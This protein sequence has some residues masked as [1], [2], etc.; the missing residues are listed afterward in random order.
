MTDS[1]VVDPKK[2]QQIPNSED[3]MHQFM[4]DVRN[5]PRLTAEEEKQLAV[6]C[7]AGDSEAIKKMVASNL[8]LVVSIAREYA[9]K[10]VPLLDL[11]QEGSIGLIKAAEKFDHTKNFRFSTYATDWIRQ[12]IAR[13]V[14][15]YACI[16]RIPHYTAERMHK[17]LRARAQILQATGEEPS[18]AVLAQSCGM[19]EQKIQ[20]LMSLYP[21]VF[22]LDYPVGED[23][24]DD[25]QTLIENLQSPQP[26]EELVRSELKHTMD[27]LLSKLEPRQQ[28]ILRLRYGMEDGTVWSAQKIGDKLGITKQRV[29]QIEQQAMAKLKTLGADLGLEDFLGE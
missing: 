26:Q 24:K 5:H 20:E 10:S 8:Q 27:I 23:G 25:L 4:Q 15:N 7:A 28:E 18:A 21:Q 11:I 29:S 19:E 1:T 3:S 12:G 13:C 9:D 2:N 22:S 16:V 17:L 6:R 14:L